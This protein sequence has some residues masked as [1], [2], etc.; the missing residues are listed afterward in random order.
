M[1]ILFTCLI[2]LSAALLPAQEYYI[3]FPKDTVLQD[4][5]FG[6]FDFGQPE[7]Y[8]PAGLNLEVS[9]TDQV[10][11]FL[12]DACYRIYRTWRI[13][14]PAY[15]P[16]LPCTLVPNP[17]PVPMIT[18]PENLPGPIVS[19]AGTAAPWAPTVVS[20]TPG[21]PATNYSTFWS[22]SANCYTYTQWI[23][24]IDSGDPLV[25]NCSTET[26]QLT[27]TSPNDPGLWNAPYWFDPASGLIDFSEGNV[28]LRKRVSDAC[29][30]RNV[31]AKFYL[32]LDLNQDGAQETVVSDL[33]NLPPGQLRYGN[34]NTPAFQGGT[35]RYF[36]TRPVQEA[37]RYRFLTKQTQI[38]NALDV[39]LVWVANDAPGVFLTPQLPP[40]THK[41]KWV[42]ADG[43]GNEANCE[44]VF[45]ISAGN[46]ANLHQ[47]HGSV[48]Q[49]ENL[50]CL[51]EPTE[52]PAGMGWRSRLEYLLPDNTA[53]SVTFSTLQADSSY[54]FWV[55][56]GVYRIAAIPPNVYWGVCQPPL[57]MVVT[58]NSADSTRV[59]FAA[60]A[61]VDCPFLETDIGI[62]GLRRCFNN[63][64][65]VKYC[66]SG[67][68]PAEDAYIVVDLDPAMS[69]VS[70]GKPAE[71]LGNNQWKF[72]LGEL[73]LDFCD[74]FPLTVY[75]D[76]NST[77]L[78]QTHCVTAHIY[79]D[80]FCL[81]PTSWSGANVELDGNCDSTNLFFRIK[82]TGLAPMTQVLDYVVI[83][84]NIINLTGSFQ[85]NP[86]EE[87]VQAVPANGST[88]RLEAEQEPG[89]PYNNMPSITIEGCGQNSQGGI[90]TGFVSQFGESDNEPAVSTD[91]MA[92]I[93]SYDP[94]DKQGFPLGYGP[95]HQIEPGQALEYLIRF[96]NTG[97]DTAFR[98]II[99]DTLSA[100]LDWQQVQPG[101]SSH[102]YRFEM[103]ANGAIAFVFDNILLPD[104]NVNEA[105]SHGFVKF[106]VAQQAEVPLK[107]FILNQAAIYFD[108]NPPVI[109]NQTSHQVGVDPLS[110]GLPGDPGKEGLPMIAVYPNPA[111]AGATLRFELPAGS[112]GVWADCYDIHGKLQCRKRL[113]AN[114]PE[115]NLENIPSGLYYFR[116][117]NAAGAMGTAKVLLR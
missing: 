44:E 9:Y 12:P 18:A 94:N 49:D 89:N 30:G 23:R 14:A 78:G 19:P 36:D 81:N 13:K 92:N 67:T 34:A 15:N 68:A 98:V 26:I 87:M 66:N 62:W 35:L 103:G 25:D 90:S 10:D 7:L 41:I 11:N 63:T 102:P 85:L 70:A 91:C 31:F 1:R 112:Y 46:P 114:R 20:I 58:E 33:L 48:R 60:T 109:T 5:D 74:Q 117:F 95:K 27:D 65:T 42:F 29:S 28:L 97:T 111:T 45:T 113:N 80:S 106:R 105:A 115:L 110:V 75:L 54:R 6:N 61:L 86:G 55:D 76:C 93:G 64:Y 101:V 21:V 104:S 77:V 22:A 52:A 3:R 53:Y 100:W 88:W 8:N 43:C 72:L 17:G 2:L 57:E 16:Q 108:F 82:N 37:C 50:N 39:E 24:I 99:R 69:F 32:Y 83:E 84:D 38:G 107:S 47:L 56:T 71:N 59:D 96:Q 79:P 4:C 116:L 40:G 73:P 51:N